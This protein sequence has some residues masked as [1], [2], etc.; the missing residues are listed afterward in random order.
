MF[1]MAP[2]PAFISLI[3]LVLVAGLTRYVSLGSVLAASAFPFVLLLCGFPAG[4]VLATLPLAVIIIIR[5]AGNLSR[6]FHGI[7]RKLGGD[8]DGRP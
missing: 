4:F 5:H 7:E 6:L 8:K 1:A 2:L 3:L